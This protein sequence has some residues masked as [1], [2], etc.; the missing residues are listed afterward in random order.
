MAKINSDQR[1]LEGFTKEVD[2]N[3]S[4]IYLAKYCQHTLL[5]VVCCNPSQREKRKKRKKKEKINHNLSQSENDGDQERK[6]D[7]QEFH[8]GHKM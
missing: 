5:H 3:C 6:E 1:I 7:P 4:C 8:F 2:L